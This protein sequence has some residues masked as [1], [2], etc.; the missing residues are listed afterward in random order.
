M[1]N[2]S[3]QDAKQRIDPENLISGQDGAYE[4]QKLLSD[5]GQLFKKS[6][7]KIFFLR[8]F[9]VCIGIDSTVNTAF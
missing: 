6:Y 7:Q 9:I 2:E 3:T 8:T 1:A 5:T 4:D